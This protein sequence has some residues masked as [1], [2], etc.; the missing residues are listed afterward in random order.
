MY[1]QG[2]KAYIGMFLMQVTIGMTQSVTPPVINDQYNNDHT[3]YL[4]DKGDAIEFEE[5]MSETRPL[6]PRKLVEPIVFEP[7]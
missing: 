4:P 6:Q 7:K 5:E 1:F 2:W 3:T